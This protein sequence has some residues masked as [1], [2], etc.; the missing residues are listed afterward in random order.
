V[1]SRI[2]GNPVNNLGGYVEAALAA[3]VREQG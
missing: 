2:E 1:T 3:Q